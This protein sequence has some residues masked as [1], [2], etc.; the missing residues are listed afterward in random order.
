MLPR[1]VIL[2]LRATIVVMSFGATGCHAKPGTL[3]VDSPVYAYKAP[4]P[5]DDDDAD[6]NDSTD[7]S[8]AAEGSGS[9]S[10]AKEK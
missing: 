7:G 1:G 2:G 5:D 10:A 3:P 6:T 4:E 8:S 9:G